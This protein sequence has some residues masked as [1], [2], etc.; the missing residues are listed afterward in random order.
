MENQKKK[1]AFQK[2]RK[3]VKKGAQK[4]KSQMGQSIYV[5]PN[6]FT[7][8]NMFFGFMSILKSIQG[9]YIMASYA[10]VAAAVFDLLDGR[11]ARMTSSE[12]KFGAEYDSLSDLISFGM[13][14]A[15]MMYFWALQPLGR[16][17]YL[18]AFFYLACGAL[19]LAR[20]NVQVGSASTTHFSGLPIPM[21][22]GIAAGSVMAFND[23]GWEGSGNVLLLGMTFLLGFVMVSNFPYRSFKDVDF[24]KRMPFRTLVLGVILLMVVAYRPELM[25]FVLFA[26]YAGLGAIFGILRIGRQPKK[27]P[28]HSENLDDEDEDDDSE[29]SEEASQALSEDLGV[30]EDFVEEEK[31]ELKKDSKPF[32]H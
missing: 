30:D 4:V 10:I 29:T 5:L 23:Q 22:A 17:G 12:S 14:P 13:A 9:D 24:K 3:K 21:A 32:T 1:K 6:L 18:V 16:V 26:S 7:T 8:G 20:F 25:V 11:V 28:Y 19:R 27:N 31:E 2:T 15:L